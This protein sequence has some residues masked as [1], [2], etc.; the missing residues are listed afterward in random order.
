[1]GFQSSLIR[2]KIPVMVSKQSKQDEGTRIQGKVE[3]D[4]RYTVEAAIIK[5]MKA[6]RT[7]DHSNLVGETTKLLATKF[8]PDPFQVK[9][10]IELLIERGYI[11]R[12]EDD[13]RIYKYIA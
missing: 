10:R 5:V 12:D 1:M 11:E 8:K 7:I 13:K 3:D 2:N 4:R 9:T 6:R